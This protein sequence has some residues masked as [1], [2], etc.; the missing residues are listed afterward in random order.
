M[1][2]AAFDLDGT[3][4]RG[5]TACE[6]IAEG[7]GRLE[8]MTE[9]EAMRADQVREVIAAREEMAGW[10]SAFTRDEL[11]RHLAA[12]RVAPGVDEGF[13]LLRDHGFRLAIVSI[14]WD[15]AVE[16][17]AARWAADY[18]VGTGLSPD[19]AITHFWPQDKA[20]WLESL[21]RDLGVEMRQVAA[22]GDSRADIP[23]LRSAGVPFW[24]GESLPA[25]LRGVATHVPD[26]DMRMVAD[27]IVTGLG[28][29]RVGS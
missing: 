5:Q 3:L 25:E 21:A 16:W 9:L 22:V 15:F 24:V 26:G 2:L 6:A 19:G 20:T 4:L 28:S 8:R 23:M 13:R 12:L 14:T 17:F 18:W 1:K 10:Y 11:R 7:I 29:A 27:G